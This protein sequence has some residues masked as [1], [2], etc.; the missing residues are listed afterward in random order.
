MNPEQLAAYLRHRMPE[1]TG[2]SVAAVARIPG[3]ASRETW[4]FD[5]RWSG[6]QGAVEG[7]FIAR[8]DPTASLLES[9]NDLEF[10]LYTALAGSGIPVPAV[11]WIERDGAW[12]ERPFFIMGKLPGASDARALVTAPEWADIR[13]RVTHQKAEI[14]AKIHQFD[15]ARVPLLDR[16]PSAATAAMYEIERWERTMRQDTLEPQPVLEL[17][18]NWLK[19]HLPP[20]P[21][22]LALVHADY[23]TGNFLYDKTGITGILDWE[24]AH[25][26]DPIEDLGWLMIKSWRWAGDERVG[27]LCSRDEFIS[28]YEAA[29]GVKVDRDALKFWEVFSNVKFAI[30]FITGTKSVV[31]GKTADL[32]LSLTAFINPGVEVELLG[33]IA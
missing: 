4:S 33:L 21:E 27:G 1:A 17:A 7:G 22:R 31:E 14:L 20:P 9:N 3:G 26:G 5:A 28:L 29:G 23:R 13:P 16:P 11:H 25:A 32:L 15:I 18:F 8:R 10:E 30:I 19:R 12:L 24:M 2:I 6:P